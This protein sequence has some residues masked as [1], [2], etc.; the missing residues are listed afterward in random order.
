VFYSVRDA[1]T[2]KRATRKTVWMVTKIRIRIQIQIRRKRGVS[3]PSVQQ[4][5]VLPPLKVALI[6]SCHFLKRPVEKQGPLD[7]PAPQS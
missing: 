1:A 5:A 3:D 7:Q 2:Q 6:L 4:P